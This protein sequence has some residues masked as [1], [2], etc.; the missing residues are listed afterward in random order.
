MSLP[1]SEALA[2]K[3]EARLQGRVRACRS[4]PHELAYEVDAANLLDVC[5]TLRDDPDLQFELLMDVAGVD[6]LVYGRD[7]WQTNSAT[8]SG[9]SRGRVARVGRARG[10]ER[11][12]RRRHRSSPTSTG[13]VAVAHPLLRRVSA[14]FGHAQRAPAPHRPAAR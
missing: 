1:S 2:A 3:V 6:Y 12:R 9:F 8:R 7:E 4:L 5:R 10:F 11:S 13:A 14:A